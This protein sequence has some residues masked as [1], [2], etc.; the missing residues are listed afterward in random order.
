VVGTQ[1]PAGT[2]LVVSSEK[3]P[4]GSQAPAPRWKK[5]LIYGAIG[6]GVLGAGYGIWR[7]R[8]GKK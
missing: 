4:L 1:V 6:V 5:P 3:T 2:N 7:W 8:K